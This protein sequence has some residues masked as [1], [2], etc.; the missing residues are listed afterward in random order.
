MRKSS[1]SRRK[2]FGAA[3]DDFRERQAAALR[4]RLS[5]G[6]TGKMLAY[7]VGVHPDT[8][9]NWA[10]A[11]AT[12]D[13]ASIATVD[14]C[15]TAQ[16]DLGFLAELYGQGVALRPAQ[17]TALSDD[18]CL[19]FTDGGALHQAPTG[20]AP[21]V[22]DTLKITAV[23]DDL[24]A[25][26]I[27]NLGWIEC[28]IRSDGR[29]RLRYALG[30]ADPKAATRARD[31]ILSVW[32]CATAVDLTMWRDGHWEQLS[33]VTVS[34]AARML[35]RASVA[36]SLK[37]FDERDWKVE[38]LSLEAVGS[39]TM[40]SLIASVKRGSDAVKAV[41][42]LGLMDTSSVFAVEGSNVTPLWIG[43]ELYL[44]ADSFVG[45]NVLDRS[46][47]KYAALVHSHV[48]QAV[49]EGP[50]FHRLK[51]EIGG[52]QRHYERVALPR[53]PDLVLTSSRLLEQGVHV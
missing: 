29:I 27:R 13:G 15:F 11:R 20:H 10:N 25:Y 41:A 49:K 33:P 47:R 51:I 52:R 19:W 23:P 43:P 3:R 7:A 28:L 5:K 34:D 35:D 32:Q 18:L 14:A 50:T 39:P 24:A 42:N 22:R 6:L 30:I 2:N 8:V 44:P 16:G 53:G 4:R 17:R 48:L 21:F 1:P 26:A 45:R 40:A 38:R 31:W 12:M 37:R 9:I 46:D 36:A